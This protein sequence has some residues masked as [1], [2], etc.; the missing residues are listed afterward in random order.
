MTKAQFK[1]LR[2]GQ[3][4]VFKK[5]YLKWIAET[6]FESHRV[7]GVINRANLNSYLIDLFITTG[8]KYQ[9]KF[10]GYSP[11]CPE[12]TIRVEVHT[13]GLTDYY[14]YKELLIK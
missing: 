4:V 13:G 11:S 10:I 6:A 2:M 12:D 7:H 5:S 1:N 14:D 3:K 8:S 9:A